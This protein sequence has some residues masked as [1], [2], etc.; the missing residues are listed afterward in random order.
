MEYVLAPKS[1]KIIP[2]ATWTGAFN[3]EQL[4][5]MQHIAFSSQTPAQ[6]G[7]A[8]GQG[9]IE[10][11][12]RRS[13]ISWVFNHQETM[14]IFKILGDVAAEL[15]ADYFGFDLDGFGEGLQFTNYD[16]SH[17]GMYGWHQDFGG[18]GISRKLSLVLQLSDPSQYEGGNLEILVTGNPTVIPKERGLITAFPAWTLHQVTPVTAGNRQSLVAWVSGKNFK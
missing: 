1:R 17:Q 16:H 6:V 14:W 7:G 15:N 8:G 4:D 5:T 12:I 3:A 18:K 10:N 2:Y 11:G 9:V 13:N